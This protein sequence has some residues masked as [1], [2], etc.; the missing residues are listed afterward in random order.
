MKFDTD[1]LEDTN[2]HF[3]TIGL[4]TSNYRKAAKRLAREALATGL[5]KSSQGNDEIYLKK[6]CNQFW[7]N[8]KSIL[9]ARVPGFG[10][11]IWKPTYILSILESLP[12]D[13]VLMYLDAG[14]YI[15]KSEKDI[16]EIREFLHFAELNDSV[17]SSNQ[18]FIEESYSSKEYLDHIQLED[19]ARK[20]NQYCA[21]FL[22][23]KNS[24]K[25][26]SL[27]KEWQ[28]LCCQ[29][30]HKFYFIA[31]G[32]KIEPPNFVHHMYDQAILSPLLKKYSTIDLDVGDKSVQGSIRLLRHR[33]AFSYGEKN[34]FVVSFFRAISLLSK[35]YLAAQR[36]IF[37]NTLNLR[38]G[39]HD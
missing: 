32:T 20:S 14:S 23:V 4:G 12:V 33:Y 36:K 34:L 13:D 8:H 5:F 19:S 22:I 17:G 6:N 35:I 39:D 24:E 7:K 29:S 11:W 25:G 37:R 16:R 27:I 9:K 1:K 18:P 26:K 30:S 31:S 10:W 3:C 38:P 15:G 28:R 21:A 2:F